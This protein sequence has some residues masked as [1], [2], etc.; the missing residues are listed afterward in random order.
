MPG[1]AGVIGKDIEVL[2]RDTTGDGDCEY[3]GAEQSRQF[4]RREPAIL[5]WYRGDNL[6]TVAHR[7]DPPI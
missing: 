1:D 4:L 7:A 2:R 6:Q 5:Y 3:G